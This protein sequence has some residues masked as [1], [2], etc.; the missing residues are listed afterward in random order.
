MVKKKQD[1]LKAEHRL[2]T[3]EE[4]LSKTESF[5]V[6]NQNVISIVVGV[7][8]VIILGYFGFQKY[9]LEPQSVEAQDQMFSAQRYFESDSLDKA[10]YGDGNRL[11][12]VDIASDYGITKAG[13][14]A[15]YYAG[16]SFLKKGNYDQA[17]DYLK[18]FESSDH[19]IG[20]MAK[21]AIGD[22]YM[23]KGDKSS[24]VSSYLEAA[25]RDDNDF[26]TPMFL[27]KAG[28]VYELENKYSKAVDTYKKIKEDYPKSNEA[29]DIEKYIARAEGFLNK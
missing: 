4:S 25:H 27:L 14:L 18:S 19:V 24:A 8:V 15:N 13:N 21:G 10:L 11:G 22:A 5:I 7:V 16:L 9:Y 26:T 17:I 29:R 28:N 23:E 12:F 20:S 1:E 2:E 6:E 3:I